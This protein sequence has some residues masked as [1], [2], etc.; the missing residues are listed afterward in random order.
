MLGIDGGAVVAGE[1]RRAEATGKPG[2]PVLLQ[3]VSVD[4]APLS[5]F[6]VIEADGSFLVNGE[7]AGVEDEE[8]LVAFIVGGS[9]VHN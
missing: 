2:G 3:G 5:G 4:V 9:P 1:D 6:A 8:K 7:R